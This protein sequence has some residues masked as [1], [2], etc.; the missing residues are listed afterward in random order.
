MAH[1]TQALINPRMYRNT[2]QEEINKL[3]TI[4]ILNT[5]EVKETMI[6]QGMDQIITEQEEDTSSYS[7]AQSRLF[8]TRQKGVGHIRCMPLP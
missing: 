3:R 1:R 2:G 8:R 5:S 4:N 6:K 7:R